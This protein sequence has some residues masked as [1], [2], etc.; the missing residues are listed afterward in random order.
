MLNTERN[1]LS[2]CVSVFGLYR[3]VSLLSRFYKPEEQTTQVVEKVFIKLALTMESV[4]AVH[5]LNDNKNSLILIKIK[6]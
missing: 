1:I 5:R 6:S 2:T 3:N 4:E